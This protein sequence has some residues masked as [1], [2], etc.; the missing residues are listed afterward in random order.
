[1]QQPTFGKL[2]NSPAAGFRVKTI[3]GT[4]FGLMSEGAFRLS[5]A[6]RADV[7]EVFLI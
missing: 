4:S 6:H 1:M 2:T 7:S 3:R 5:D